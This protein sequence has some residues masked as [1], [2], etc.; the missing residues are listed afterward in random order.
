VVPKRSGML[1]GTS[2]PVAELQRLAK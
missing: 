1:K 2:G